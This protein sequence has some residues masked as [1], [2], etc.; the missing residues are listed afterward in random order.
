[1]RLKLRRMQTKREATLKI[2]GHTIADPRFRALLRSPVCRAI[3][4]IL[5][6]VFFFQG[7]AAWI[8]PTAILPVFDLQFPNRLCGN[9]QR[10]RSAEHRASHQ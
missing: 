7:Y 4:T 2:G 10:P 3:F 6:T 8:S 9:L 1:M 5:P